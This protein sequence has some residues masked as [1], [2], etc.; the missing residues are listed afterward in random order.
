MIVKLPLFFFRTPEAEREKITEKVG[1]G[2]GV[3]GL[4][5]PQ[6][7]ICR[8]DALFASVGQ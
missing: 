6:N 8:T 5:G 4:L 3:N 7:R 1:V 2:R